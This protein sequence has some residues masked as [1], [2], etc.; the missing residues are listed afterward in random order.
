MWKYVFLLIAYILGSI[1]FSYLLGKIFKKEDIRKHGSG[2]TGTTNA[3]RV[4]GEIIGVLVLLL[5]SLKAG[6]LV[7]LMTH[8]G[9]FAGMDL[10]H[11]L[12]YGFMSIIGHMF[13]VWL[14]FDGGKGVASSFGLLLAYHYMIAV[15]LMPVFIITL[16]VTRYVSVS[17]LMTSAMACVTVIIMYFMSPNPLYDVYLIIITVV[18]TGLIFWR[19]KTNI[20][21]LLNHEENRVTFLDRLEKNAED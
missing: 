11:P 8:T 20:R 2:N 3:F 21:R 4:F 16:I 15:I 17:S 19:H 10:F 18:A 1:P 9:V 14:K 5:D 7:F 12:I 6:L 13:P